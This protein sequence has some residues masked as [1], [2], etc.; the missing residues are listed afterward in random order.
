MVVCS[1]CFNALYG[2]PGWLFGMVGSAGAHIVDTRGLF[3]ISTFVKYLAQSLLAIS[4]IIQLERFFEYYTIGAQEGAGISV[5]VYGYDS[6]FE[7]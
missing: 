3:C 5:A 2:V 7:A 1:G 6:A 4:G